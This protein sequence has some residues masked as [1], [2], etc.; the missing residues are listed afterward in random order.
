MAQY[1]MGHQLNSWGHFKLINNIC[2]YDVTGLKQLQNLD[3]SSNQLTDEGISSWIYNLT[4]LTVLNLKENRLR[5]PNIMK[6]II[7][8]IPF[9]HMLLRLHLAKNN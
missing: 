9:K 7:L 2:S 8:Y 6:G 4:A 5:D 3:L 1:E